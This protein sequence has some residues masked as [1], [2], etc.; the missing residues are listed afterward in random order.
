MPNQVFQVWVIDKEVRKFSRDWV[1]AELFQ[2]T[3]KRLSIVGAQRFD[4]LS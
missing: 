3:A 2:K 4:D 1:I